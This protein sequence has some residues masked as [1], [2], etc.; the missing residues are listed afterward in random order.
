MKMK[1]LTIEKNIN[2]LIK[3]IS[4]KSFL[5][6]NDGSIVKTLYVGN[7]N[8]NVAEDL[9]DL[10]GLRTTNYLRNTC[11]VILTLCSKTNNSR[12][13]AFVTGPE[14]VLNELVKLSRIEFQEKILVRDEAKKKSSTPS[15]T[16]LRQIPVDVSQNSQRQTAFNRTAVVPGHKSFSEVTKSKSNN[17][18]NTLIFSDSILKGIR[19]YQFNRILR[20]REAKML[21]FPDALSNEN[22]ITSMF[23]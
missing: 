4:E 8:K 23:I 9:I 13:F 3:C 14:H 12:A 6:S 10:F 7:L 11:L 17:S 19:M 1:I 18:Y 15:L 22:Y 5:N 21:N 20:N 2:L 16:P